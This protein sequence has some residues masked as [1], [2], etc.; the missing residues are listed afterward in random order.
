MESLKYERII[1]YFKEND[2]IVD[3]LELPEEFRDDVFD[4]CF[5]GVIIS[6]EDTGCY[7]LQNR[8]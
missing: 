5:D 1:K 8:F 6:Y 2:R 7:Y 3:W 4:A